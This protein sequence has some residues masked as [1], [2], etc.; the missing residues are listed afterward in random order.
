MYGMT[1]LLLPTV[2]CNFRCA[3]C[4]EPESQRA[5]EDIPLNIS[6][7][8]ASLAELWA[9]ERHHGDDVGIHGGEAL[10]IKHRDLEKILK[11]SYR[12]SEEHATDT[13]PAYTSIVTNASLIRDVHIRM[14]KRYNTRLNISVD[15]PPE[16]NILRGPDPSDPEVTVEYNRL[17]WVKLRTLLKE[18]IPFSI[19]CILHTENA[20][21]QE[22]IDKLKDWL[23]ELHQM[24]ITGGRLN[25]MYAAPWSKEYELTNEQ[26]ILA[27][28]QLADFTI[29]TRSRWLPFRE[30][31]DNLCGFGVSPCIFGQCD[32]FK[33]NTVAILPDGEITNCDRTFSYGM[34][35]RSSAPKS[36]ARYDSLRQTQCAKCEYWNICNAGC[37]TEGTIDWRDKTRFCDALYATYKH[38]ENKILDLF[39]NV[40]LV[41]NPRYKQYGEAF[42]PMTYAYCDRTS[43]YGNYTLKQETLDR[44][45]AGKG[46]DDL[47]AH[48]DPTLPWRKVEGGWYA[49][50]DVMR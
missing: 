42:L 2:R 40:I 50:S 41:N 12:Y 10:M 27:Y 26:L 18:K 33:T 39:P 44:L 20:G 6:A 13:Q 37:P 21:S 17:L 30:M 19:M 9:T 35:C 25:Q 43:T 46:D 47:P 29:D 31:I 14:F 1:I 23:V 36:L 48:L 32:P 8:G 38:L 15:G 24:G 3:Y 5:E 28:T 45:S 7:I 34:H 11:L 4:F 49:D 22:K 16:L